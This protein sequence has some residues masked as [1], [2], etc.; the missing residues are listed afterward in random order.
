MRLTEYLARNLD[1]FQG[2]EGQDILNHT[3]RIDASRVPVVDGDAIPTG[4]IEDI[5]GTVLDFKTA[6]KIGSRI[7]EAIGTCGVG[8]CDGKCKT[9]WA[10][11]TILGRLYW[12]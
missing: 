7:N 12:I 11:N 10:T 4:P 1:A 8:K 3:L 5:R 2:A 9:L 6:R